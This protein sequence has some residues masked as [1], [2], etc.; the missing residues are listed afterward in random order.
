MSRTT[1]IG[2]GI[3]L[4]LFTGALAVLAFSN[5]DHVSR[6]RGALLHRVAKAE[7]TQELDRKWQEQRNDES[8]MRE[9]H[10][11]ELGAEK[12]RRAIPVT[13]CDQAA[14]AGQ[15]QVCLKLA[16]RAEFPFGQP[17]P[18]R[19]SWR[20]LPPGAYIRVWADNAAPAGTRFLYAG[21]QG[22]ITPGVF[23]GKP[24]GGAPFVWDG[25]SVYCAP[26]DLPTMCD[27]GDVGQFALHADILTGSDPYWPSWP[28]QHPVPVRTLATAAPV[29]VT[30]TGAPRSFGSRGTRYG[31]SLVKS[32][33]RAA[34][35]RAM[36]KG[37][38][39]D[40]S[41]DLME[42]IGP[43]EEGWFSWCAR[44][45]LA[46]PL[47]G[48]MSICFPRSR[49]DAY[50]VAIRRSDISVSGDARLAPGLIAPA[51]ARAIAE[52]LALHFI[53][54]RYRFDHYPTEA[55]LKGLGPHP[56]GSWEGPD[57]YDIAGQT[58]S[59][60]P[61]EKDYQFQRRAARLWNLQITWASRQN[62]RANFITAGTGSFWLISV[63]Q[64]VLDLNGDPKK[65]RV[66]YYY[67]VDHDSRA[68]LLGSWDRTNQ[69]GGPA[70]A[71]RPEQLICPGSSGRAQ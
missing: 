25:R 3:S 52:G 19:L 2:C 21:P 17:V 4:L 63:E 51:K 62:T 7:I 14:K 49:R 28:P 65:P 33:I 50:G 8:W 22:A 35:A 71:Q 56:D 58:V 39:G 69:I 54:G 42:Q 29:T 18:L 45:P 31:S 13:P 24:D 12:L 46:A 34:L 30:M 47:A 9:R 27:V 44:L 48:T 43:W 11:Q 60:I 61:D 59:R 53:K 70:D 67:R 32:T 57:R 38:L 1:G 40:V 55:D 6:W 26:A 37:L 16:G 15:P 10:E 23:G 68:C 66:I 36:P 64:A 41:Y 5:N 20:N